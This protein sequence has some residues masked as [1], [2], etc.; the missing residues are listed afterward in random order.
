M[1]AL[2]DAEFFK[3]LEQ[4]CAADHLTLYQ[5]STS[6]D[7]LFE[8]LCCYL[9]NLLHS[10]L[11]GNLELLEWKIVGA[12]NSTKVNEIDLAINYSFQMW[13]LTLFCH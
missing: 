8:S 7:I 3:C 1:L 5:K 4:I 12:S 11:S 6:L 2:P 10:C 13:F 9:K